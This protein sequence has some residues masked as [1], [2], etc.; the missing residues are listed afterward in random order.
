VV[1]IILETV[2]EKSRT[3]TDNHIIGSEMW[4]IK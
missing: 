2:P 1:Y 4:P 3:Y